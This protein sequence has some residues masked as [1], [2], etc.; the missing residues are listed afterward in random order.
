MSTTIPTGEELM[1]LENNV[2]PAMGL[3]SSGRL[4]HSRLRGLRLRLRTVFL[5]V[6]RGILDVAYT[7]E[8][9]T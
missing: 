9:A 3:L 7:G 4:D 1:T 2:L 6:I 5:R 8:E